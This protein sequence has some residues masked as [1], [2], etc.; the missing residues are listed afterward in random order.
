MSLIQAYLSKPSTQRVLNRKPGDKGFS[1]IELVVVVAVLAI[2]S[3]IAI[4]AFTNIS[5]KARASA[6]SN[7]IA[8]IAKECATKIA[9]AG[10]GTYGVP[11]MDGYRPTATNSNIG[12]FEATSAS[13]PVVTYHT[14][15]SRNCP[16]DGAIGLTS[17]DN[18]KYPTF[19]YNIGTGIK[20]CTASGAALTRGCPTSG[21]PW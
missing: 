12:W 7:T 1:L 18:S 10:T 13:T 4:P 19:E 2:L 6:A 9:D 8:Q 21:G 17:S 14:S 5:E 20:K 15:G 16:T 3:A 11:T